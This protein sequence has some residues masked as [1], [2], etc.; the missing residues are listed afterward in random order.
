M[1][2]IVCPTDVILSRP[3]RACPR[4]RDNLSVEKARSYTFVSSSLP[5]AKNRT[6]HTWSR[7]MMT[8]N[9]TIDALEKNRKAF[10]VVNALTDSN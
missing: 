4:R 1:N 6:I 5:P 3:A 8:R 10:I 9:E 2:G 7:G